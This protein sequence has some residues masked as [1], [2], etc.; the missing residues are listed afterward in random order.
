[1]SEAYLT[2]AKDFVQSGVEKAGVPLTQSLE[3][4]LTFTFAR[5][6]GRHISVD[7]L[8]VRV[9]RA[10]DE[11]ASREV[12]R[13]LADQC[14]LAC[15][16]F[17]GRLSRI[18]T[19]RHYIGLGQATYDAAAMTEQAYGFVLMRDV[20]ASAVTAAE[21]DP[22]ALLDKARGGSTTARRDLESQQVIIGPWS[23]PRPGLLWR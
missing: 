16:L 13:D 17:E 23:K 12:M 6:I 20:I 22:V 21:S 11:G 9:T 5:Y 1:M 7:M 10:M 8:T 15:A 3:V 2:A 18:G 4:Y 19:V 14:L